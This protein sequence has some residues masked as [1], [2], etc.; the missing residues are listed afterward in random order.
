MTEDHLRFTWHWRRRYRF[1]ILISMKLWQFLAF[2]RASRPLYWSIPLNAK[3]SPISIVSRI[4]SENFFPVE[5]IG[6]PQR[7]SPI[8][9]S[10]DNARHRYSGNVFY[11]WIYNFS[12]CPSV[13]KTC[14]LLW[15]RNV[16]WYYAIIFSVC[17]TRS[18]VM[19]IPL[20]SRWCVHKKYII[21]RVKHDGR[22]W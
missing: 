10:D 11:T 21:S 6:M 7:G 12:D 9:R 16:K 22:E 18:F 15:P 3:T 17:G 20:Y 8:F 13:Q 2:I 5:T 1:S 14:L 19:N 4:F